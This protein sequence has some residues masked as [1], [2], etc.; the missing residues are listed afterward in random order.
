MSEI[1]ITYECPSAT[2]P[3]MNPGPD[4][5]ILKTGD[6][7]FIKQFGSKRYDSKSSSHCDTQSRSIS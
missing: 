3:T 6:G 4:V 1:L 7:G 5:R 2:P